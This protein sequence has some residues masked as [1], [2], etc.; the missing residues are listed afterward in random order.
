MIL[1]LWA[2][3]KLTTENLKTP[4]TSVNEFDTW[5]QHFLTFYGEVLVM[6]VMLT[7]QHLIL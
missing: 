2:L 7:F 4:L 5:W 3:S 6:N 1:S